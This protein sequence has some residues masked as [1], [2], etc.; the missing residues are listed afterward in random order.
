MFFIDSDVV[1]NFIQQKNPGTPTGRPVDPS[2]HDA[3]PGALGYGQRA[4]TGITTF[5]QFWVYLLP[6]FGAWVADTYL[7][8]FKT[9]IVSVMIAI[10][11]HVILTVSAVPSVLGNTSG[12]LACFIIGVIIMGVGTGGFKPNISPLVAEQIPHEKMRVI[13]TEKGERV[14]VDPAVTSN[15]VYNWFYLFI[16]IGA[17]G[18]LTAVLC[19]DHPTNSTHSWTNLHGVCRALCRLLA[20][21]YA[22]DDPVPPVPPR[23]L[24]VPQHVPQNSA[25]G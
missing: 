15:R 10:V 9:I 8:R 4:S 16:N 17:L 13:T 21:L 3:Q 22:S 1:T 6:L 24:P 14:I 25:A 23:P 12:A 5:N 2:A 20:L 11:G 19:C 7:G 18:K